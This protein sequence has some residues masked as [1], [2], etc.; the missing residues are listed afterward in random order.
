[1]TVF[2]VTGGARSGK[3]RFAQHLATKLGEGKNVIF[4]ATAPA[5]DDEMVERI[6][7]HRRERPVE[8]VT[9]EER[10]DVVKVLE[11][12]RHD[13]YLID[14]LSLLLNNWMYDLKLT[15]DV[16]KDL[17]HRLITCLSSTELDVVLVSN[18]LGLGLVPADK[19]SRQ[20][21]DWLGWLNQAV[22]KV[23]DSVYLV[24]SGVAIDLKQL[25]GSAWDF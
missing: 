19:L 16:F 23:A 7:R 18:E 15:E 4:V 6:E 12:R 13:V 14:C 10:L 22:A 5:V 24:V 11:E 3:S 2:F 20:Y 25:P 8:W 21:R 17:T 1:M 9:V